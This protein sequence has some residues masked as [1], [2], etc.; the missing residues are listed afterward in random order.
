MY[1][2]DSILVHRSSRPVVRTIIAYT[3]YK[4]I[5]VR[6]QLVTPFLSSVIRQPALR[7]V[8]RHSLH[9]A[10]KCLSATS[11]QQSKL[12][13]PRDRTA[14]SRRDI[15]SPASSHPVTAE[16]STPISAKAILDLIKV[17][18]S[19]YPL[20]KDLTLS[21]DRI[22]EIVKEA[23]L[24]IPSCFNGQS[25]RV[26]VLFGAEHEKLWDITS[27]ALKA[28]VPA[29]SWKDTGDK[30]GMFKGAAG[31][32]LFFEDIDV[33]QAQQDAY[34]TYSDKFPSWATQSDGMLQF[35]IWVALEA[36]G[37]GGNLQHYNPVIDQKVAAQW[38]IPQSWKLNAQL[39]FGGKTGE[40][41]EKSFKPIEERV[42]VYGA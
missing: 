30:L 42:K 39:V 34:P 3:E 22:Q 32:I 2:R 38:N 18:R 40:A 41:G 6:P 31:S 15:H 24:H 29:D 27:E 23:T 7:Q 25:T 13:E 20:S 21:T 10:H 19:Y 4:N 26:V 1:S 9:P 35:T 28:I 14:T 5:M 33:V 36:E 11:A 17:R 8:S 37:L 12:V 16:M